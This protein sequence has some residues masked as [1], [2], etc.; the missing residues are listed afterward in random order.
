ME[1]HNAVEGPALRFTKQLKKLLVIRRIV[2]ELSLAD[3]NLRTHGF[4][5]TYARKDATFPRRPSRRT[6]IWKFDT[7]TLEQLADLG[8]DRPAMFFYEPRD[9]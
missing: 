7:W 8:D 3:H 5:M 2:V 4:W 9:A 6:E 1:R